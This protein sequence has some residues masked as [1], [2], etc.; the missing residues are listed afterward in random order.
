M[1]ETK[2]VSEPKI[3]YRTFSY[4]TEVRWEGNRSGHADSNGRPEFH[5]SSPPEFKG[6][7]GVCTPEDL[8]VVSVEACTMLT[9]MALANRKNYRF[10][11]I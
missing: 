9:F 8:F 3:R 4:S 1:I 6:E 11:P 7:V 2:E 5:I 10:S